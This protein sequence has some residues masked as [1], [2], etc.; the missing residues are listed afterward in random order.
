MRVLAASSGSLII[1][2]CQMTIANCSIGE[3]L[4]GDRKLQMG[5]VETW[6]KTGARSLHDFADQ[7]HVAWNH[8]TRSN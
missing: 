1:A 7:D 5:N 8:A 4:I 6:V 2:D 3:T